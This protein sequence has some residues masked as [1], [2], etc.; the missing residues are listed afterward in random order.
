MDDTVIA[1]ASQ[2]E[3]KQVYLYVT[4]ASAGVVV[5]PGK[6]YRPWRQRARAPSA[7][8]TGF[9]CQGRAGVEETLVPLASFPHL[10]QCRGDQELLGRLGAA[11]PCSTQPPLAPSS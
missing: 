1:T 2:E 3:L 5:A 6:H 4:S 10:A 11:V 8:R 9:F 7:S